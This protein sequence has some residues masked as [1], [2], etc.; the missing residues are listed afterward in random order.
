MNLGQ[1]RA[2]LEARGYSRFTDA[3]LNTWLNTAVTRFEDYPFNWPWLKTTATGAAPLTIADLRRVLS[4]ANTTT[5]LPLQ[6]VDADALI[7]YVDTNLSRG[8]A[9]LGWYL[10]SSTSVAAFPV[11]AALSVRY[12]KYSPT[13]SGDSDTPLIPAAYHQ[14]WVDLAEVEVLRYGV[15]D[16]AAAAAMDAVVMA[17]VGEIAGVFGMMGQPEYSEVPMAGASVDG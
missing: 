13:L 2:D 6:P 16:Q 12:V 4:V 14:T 11:T 3:R 15:K 1:A 17:R 5:G 9:A 10:A 7:E 8:G